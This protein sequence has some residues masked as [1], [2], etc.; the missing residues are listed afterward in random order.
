MENHRYFIGVNTNFAGSIL[1]EY[2]PVSKHLNN[3]NLVG[4]RVGNA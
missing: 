2:Y 1:Q 3:L 4:V